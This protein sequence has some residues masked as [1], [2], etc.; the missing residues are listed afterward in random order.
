MKKN[1]IYKNG[2]CQ[3][4]AASKYTIRFRPFEDGS[5]DVDF[6]AKASNKVIARINK[7][8]VIDF[9]LGLTMSWQ[10]GC[11]YCN[12][13]AFYLCHNCDTVICYTDPV[14]KC[15]VCGF[16]TELTGQIKSM[17]SNPFEN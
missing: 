2:A 10:K 13:E 4:D 3:Y 1:A 5:W 17:N 8:E 14:V 16:E 11:P 15:S 7:S 6:V 9:S 12:N